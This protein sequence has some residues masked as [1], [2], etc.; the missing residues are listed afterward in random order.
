MNLI[1]KYR[2]P[3]SFIKCIKYL[4]MKDAFD[5]INVDGSGYYEKILYSVPAESVGG[6]V[7]FDSWCE[8]CRMYVARRTQLCSVCLFPPRTAV[9]EAP[10]SPSEET[11][12]DQGSGQGE[13]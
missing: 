10:P 1:T 12:V 4:K 7:I 3:A 5:P 13:A 2:L 8:T 6:E 11:G 9:Q